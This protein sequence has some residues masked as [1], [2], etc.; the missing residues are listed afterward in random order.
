[1]CLYLVTER[2]RREWCRFVC[3]DSPPLSPLIQGMKGVADPRVSPV[4]LTGV[5]LQNQV[6]PAAEI[7]CPEPRKILK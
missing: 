4:F 7:F 3:H 1:M 6:T 5:I 2:K